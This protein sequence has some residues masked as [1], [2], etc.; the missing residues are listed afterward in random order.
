MFNIP[1]AYTTVVVRKIQLDLTQ[2][3]KFV[4]Y[5]DSLQNRFL[6]RTIVIYIMYFFYRCID[7]NIYNPHPIKL[8]KKT[9]LWEQVQKFR[10]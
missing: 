6:D 7:E 3:R 2:K 1:S 5:K 9:D 8:K 10:H 4:F